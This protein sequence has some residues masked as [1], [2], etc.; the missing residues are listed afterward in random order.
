MK[1]NDEKTYQ[2]D[3]VKKHHDEK[4]SSR[5]VMIDV[6]FNNINEIKYDVVFFTCQHCFISQSFDNK[7]ESRNHMLNIH[8]FDIRFF[9]VIRRL[10]QTNKNVNK[11]L[12]SNDS[13]LTVKYIQ[14]LV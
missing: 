12:R 5:N 6:F 3:E 7:N 10:Q 8:Q 9:E 13:T 14:K 4:Q 1:S 11:V 2:I